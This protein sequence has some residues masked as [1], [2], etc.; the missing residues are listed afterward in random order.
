MVASSPCML[1]S[2]EQ[3]AS[4]AAS[5]TGRYSGLQPAITALIA[6]FSTV[7]SF[8]SGGTIATTS[9][10][11]S[12]A[13]EHA[14]HPGLG[15]R[16]D[17]QPVGPAAIEG[18]F[19]LVFDRGQ[20]DAAAGERR[21]GE[22]HAS[23]RRSGSDRP[24]ANRSLVASRAARAPSASTPVNASHCSRDQPTMRSTSVPRLHP[25]QRR[26]R[27]DL[28]MPGDVELRVVDRTRATPGSWGSSWM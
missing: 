12:R 20:L 8:R 3:A 21:A 25:Q 26:N 5:T 14:Q 9:P 22:A 1:N 19:H 16:H 15:R 18:R 23:A 17:R 7:T 11:A 6:T 2:S 24:R 28:V 27:L 4:T 10:V 13:V